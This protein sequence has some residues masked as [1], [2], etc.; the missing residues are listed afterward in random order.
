MTKKNFHKFGKVNE[1]NIT[2]KSVY[3]NIMHIYIVEEAP[4]GYHIFLKTFFCPI[5]AIQTLILD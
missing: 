2:Y 1:R 5:F 3:V 4:R